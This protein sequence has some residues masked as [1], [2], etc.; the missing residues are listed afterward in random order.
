MITMSLLWGIVS[1]AFSAMAI[2]AVKFGRRSQTFVLGG[3]ICC[4]VS[5]I[6]SYI[7]IKNMSYFSGS[8]SGADILLLIVFAVVVPVLCNLLA[9]AFE[10]LDNRD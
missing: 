6:L 4:C 2:R 9:L 8:Y 7:D 3:I 5:A 10:R 1:L